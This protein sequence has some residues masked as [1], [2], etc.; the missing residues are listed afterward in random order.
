MRRLLLLALV[1]LVASATAL[2]ADSRTP[3]IGLSGTVGPICAEL[4]TGLL[5][6]VKQRQPCHAGEVRRY[7]QI[8]FPKLRRGPR[9][10]RGVPGPAGTAGPVGP[11]GAVGARGTTGANGARGATGAAGPPGSGA[12]G[13][14]GA[15]G[16]DGATG[17][18]GPTGARGPSGTAG[19][20]GLGDSLFYL[21]INANGTPVKFGG[22][23][24][25]TPDCDPGHDGLILRVVFQGPPIVVP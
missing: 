23:V 12:P 21:C 5:H 22:P 3:R 25:G 20:T 18:R 9:G 8:R 14:R 2:A 15:T 11:T 19:A 1:G 10:V 13:P 17:T 6:Y 7:W 16:R 4:H 24:D